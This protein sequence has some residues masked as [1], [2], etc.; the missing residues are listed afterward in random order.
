MGPICVIRVYP[1][2]IDCEGIVRLWRHLCPDDVRLDR[3]FLLEEPVFVRSTILL[4]LI[5]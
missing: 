1:L 2:L 4:S 3:P 5:T